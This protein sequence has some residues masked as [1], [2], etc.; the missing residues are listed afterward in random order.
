MLISQHGLLSAVLPFMRISLL[1]V[2]VA[3]PAFAT[4]ERV[5]ISKDNPLREALC[6]SMTCVAPGAS[7][8][9][10]VK[11][12]KSGERV[13]F[14]VINSAGAVK[15]TMVTPLDEDGAVPSMEAARAVTKM[16]KAIEGPQPVEKKLKSAVAKKSV[17]H[18]KML[19]NR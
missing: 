8:D 11:A 6:I 14:V 10:T 3:V 9:A 19:A 2:L 1:M 16:V 17:P 7:H 12:Q 4:G 13:E 18:G 5:A 15:L